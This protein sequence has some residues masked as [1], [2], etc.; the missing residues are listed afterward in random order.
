MITPPRTIESLLEALGAEPGF[1][2]SVLGDLAEEFTARA[3]SDGMASAESWY[4]REALRAAPHLL[5]S[6]ARRLR[7]RGVAHL[8]GVMVSCYVSLLLVGALVAATGY[9]VLRTLGLRTEYHLPWGNP[10]A[11]LLLLSAS[12]ALGS[13]VATLGGYI[14]AWLGNEAPL[15]TA[16]A[17]AVVLGVIEV[18][19]AA[20]AP[21]FPL[22]YRFAVP[23]VVFVGITVGGVLRVGQIHRHDETTVPA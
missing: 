10:L 21:R 14:A 12:L 5:W 1:R 16:V 7:A 4:R 22:W 23:I 18:V 11:A 8:V 6:W 13:L 9:V 17:F 2:D 3:E 20:L 15:A 19:V